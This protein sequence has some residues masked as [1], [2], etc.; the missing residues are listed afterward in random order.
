MFSALTSFK[1]THIKCNLTFHGLSLWAFTAVIKHRVHLLPHLLLFLHLV[2][3]AWT[4]ILLHMPCPSGILLQFPV[5][6]Q[7]STFS[8]LSCSTYTLL[9]ERSYEKST[10]T[11]I[12]LIILAALCSPSSPTWACSFILWNPVAHH[13]SSGWLPLWLMLRPFPLSVWTAQDLAPSAASPSDFFLSPY[14]VIALKSAILSSSL[15]PL[16]TYHLTYALFLLPSLGKTY[17]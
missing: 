12:A 6:L 14:K 8:T 1:I 10:L 5:C 7:I 16:R 4:H 15:F 3:T 11:L 13:P 9:P 17:L 2:P